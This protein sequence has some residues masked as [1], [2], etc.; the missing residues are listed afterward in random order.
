[1][2]SPRI[3]LCSVDIFTMTLKDAQENINNNNN[4]NYD[5]N[6]WPTS[7]ELFAGWFSNSITGE[8]VNCKLT[9]CRRLF[10]CRQVEVSNLP[11]RVYVLSEKDTEQVDDVD[12]TKPLSFFRFI[13]WWT[14]INK[15]ALLYH[16]LFLCQVAVL[17]S[18]PVFILHSL[19]TS[20]T[21]HFILWCSCHPSASC[22]SPGMSSWG[23][24]C[25]WWNGVWSV[26][27]KKKRGKKKN[28]LMEEKIPH[29][30]LPHHAALVCHFLSM[31]FKHVWV[32]MHT[33]THTCAH[34]HAD[35]AHF[36]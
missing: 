25:R 3:T 17:S 11:V 1:M 22:I 34:T 8:S 16:F 35:A 23:L 6:N 33:R 30:V 7:R 36:I 29:C 2:I 26:H 24:C 32:T 31:L 9:G 18:P 20:L 5:S 14:G 10:C 4:K 13:D 19:C 15:R 12:I 28:R 27:K 21:S